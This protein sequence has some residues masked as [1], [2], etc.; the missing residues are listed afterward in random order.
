MTWKRFK[1]LAE[2]RGMKD[3]D[4]IDYI[5]VDLLYEKKPKI[6]VEKGREER[7]KKITLK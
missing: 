3:L 7:T 6:F 5:D 4:K 2:R 1:R